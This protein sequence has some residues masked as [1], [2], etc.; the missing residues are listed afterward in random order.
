MKRGWVLF[1]CEVRNQ[2]GEVVV[3]GEWRTL[4][5]RQRAR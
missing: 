4:H 1:D 2:D 3:E 5:L